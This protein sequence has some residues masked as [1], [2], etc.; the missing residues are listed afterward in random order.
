MRKEEVRNRVYSQC[1]EFYKHRSD[2]DIV[3]FYSFGFHLS[4]KF[5]RKPPKGERDGHGQI[6]TNYLPT[7]SPDEDH[8]FYFKDMDEL[9]K[10][11]D[12]MFKIFWTKERRQA[13]RLSSKKQGGKK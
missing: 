2:I 7:D 10:C 9:N 1:V 4:L 11:I 12:R 5:Y 6:S 3:Q 13:F 8:I